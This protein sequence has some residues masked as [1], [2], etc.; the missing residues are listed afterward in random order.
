MGRKSIYPIELKRKVIE[1]YEPM[2]HGYKMLA[3]KYDLKR[4][5]VRSWILAEQKRLEKLEK[6]QDND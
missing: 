5:T 1:E 2:T 4:D 3:R 6:K